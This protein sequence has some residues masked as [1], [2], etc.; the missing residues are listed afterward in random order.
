K[1][2]VF[3]EYTQIFQ[4]VWRQIRDFFY[5]PQLH[6]KDWLAMKKK[7]EPL[8][9]YVGG[10]SDLNYILGQMIGELTASHEYIINTGDESRKTKDEQQVSTGLL[11]AD[12]KPDDQTGRYQFTHIIHG[13]NWNRTLTNPLEA[14]HIEIHEGD[15]LLSID[16]VSITTKENY[17]RYL[18][19]KAGKEITITINSK[20]DTA[21]AKKYTIKTMVLTDELNMRQYEWVENNYQ[22]VKNDTKERVGYIHLS[23]MVEKGIEE[24]EQGF[25]AERFREGLI[26]DVRGNSGGFVSWF[27]IDKLERQISSMTQTRDFQ[28][29]AYPHGVHIGPIIYICDETTSSDGEI[30]IHQVQE[31]NLGTVIGTDTW[32][33]LIGYINIIPTIDNGIITQSNVGFADLNGNWLIENEG[34]HPDVIVEN[35]PEDILAGRDLQLEKAMELILE[36]LNTNPPEKLTSP[37]YPKR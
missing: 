4:D 30:F 32:G 34:A 35:N 8:I 24:F 28:P 22:K 13:V 18:I 29:M 16:G 17:L 21:G 2:D 1:I 7:Y 3:Q 12:L 19:D 27:L 6:G 10:R 5:D 15:Y 9:P 26:I 25:R 23:N 36:K 31:N 20:P 11:G 33:G 14:P 37:P